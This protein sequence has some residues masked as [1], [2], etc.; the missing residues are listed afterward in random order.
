MINAVPENW[1]YDDSLEM[2]FLFYQCTDEL[3]SETAP[4][5]YCLPQHN[6]ITLFCELD[7]VYTLLK[8]Y[9]I[10]D[11]YYSNYVP[12]IIDEFLNCLEKD[13]L[14]KG[15]IGRRIFTLKTGFEEAKQ[16]SV[17]LERWCNLFKQICSPERYIKIYKEEIV[18]LVT[19]TKDKMQL[20]Y[21]VKNLY[22][23][24][25]GVGY[26]REYLYTYSK[27]FFNNRYAEINNLKQIEAFLAAFDG[28]KKDFE[29]LVLMDLSAMEHIDNLGGKSSIGEKLEKID[30][31]KERTTFSNDTS[32]TE[33]FKQ[34]DKIVHNSEQ[35]KNIAV[36]RYCDKGLDPYSLAI[37]FDN[38]MYFLQIFSRYFKHFK[39]SKRVI[40]F[41][42]K[43][44]DGLYRDFSLPN[45][46]K[47]RP[48]VQQ[49]LI[50]SRIKN[51]LM[52]KSMSEDAFFSISHAIGMHSEALDS[53]N[54]TM[55]LRTFWTALETLF[56]N[57]SPDS[58]KENVVNSVVAI[59]QKTYILKILRLIYSQILSCVSNANMQKLG[60]LCFKDFVEF[61]VVNKADSDD[62]KILYDFLGKNLLLRS[63]IYNLRR[64][65][66]NGEK[67]K[68]FLYEH[69]MRVEWQLKRIYRIRNI[70]TH[71][72]VE[73]SNIEPA[74]NHLHNY[75]DYSVNYLLC[76]SENGDYLTTIS[77]IVF[78]AKI[79]NEIQ[80]ECLKKHKDI[81]MNNYYDCL[82]GP[83][84]NLMNYE[85]EY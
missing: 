71:I 33:L 72:G 6:T 83:D 70:A 10:V 80:N 77:S 36:M 19:E 28:V 9:N 27:K 53:K 68:E 39:Q 76:K 7:E 15:L 79:D 49:H 5:T 59:I 31:E 78:E 67:I 73:A 24:L 21:S 50:D 26:S 64:D 35:S 54:K 23:S 42:I 20:Y 1:K 65:L 30:V 38:Y 17:L 63:R 74:L 16:N 40:K 18:R 82:F 81:D 3:L 60:L 41:L 34:Y 47:K 51:I 29:F 37:D 32:V 4:D 84:K 62:M 22:I 25:I 75:F 61:F 46:L 57:P 48:F 12:P 11:Q 85:F 2:L 56:S 14:L 52:G 44:D 58:I 13:K 8:G 43:R 45:V 55:L 69:K 66:D